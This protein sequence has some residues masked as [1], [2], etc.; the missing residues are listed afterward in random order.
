MITG[1]K[2]P[3]PVI[4]ENGSVL[5]LYKKNR[6]IW[7]MRAPSF[8]GPYE[9]IGEIFHASKENTSRENASMHV[10][11]E[12]P[13]LWRDARGNFHALMHPLEG[14]MRGH[15]FSEDGVT[16]H[17]ADP[18]KRGRAAFH[19]SITA[20]DGKLMSVPDAE[21]LRIW[22]NPKTRQP[23]LFFYASGG[24][25]QPVAADGAQRSF[26]V[27]QR[28]RTAVPARQVQRVDDNRQQHALTS[29]DPIL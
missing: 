5:A 23:E 8:K 14:T 19:T 22:V 17:W 11:Q 26:T 6:T 25:H 1:V 27:V 21:R 20:P 9:A 13:T 15:G 2:N 28:I 3:A 18:A 4:F 12:D 7:A 24:D 16:W 29:S 10:S